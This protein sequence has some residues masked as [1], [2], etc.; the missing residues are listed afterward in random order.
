MRGNKYHTSAKW[1]RTVDGITFHSRA[2]ATR[3]E[4]LKLLL[5]AG[6]IHN[7][8]LQPE[9]VLIPP[10]IH[11]KHGKFRGVKYRADFR[12]VDESGVLVV[13][14]VKGYATDSYRIKKTLLI[15][16]H[17]EINFREIK[18]DY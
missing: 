12:Y 1:L 4:E 13:E 15:W 11:P 6:R 18:L 10:F 16:R 9:Y 8:E 3:Y 2:E 14:D 17:P 7:L 5:K